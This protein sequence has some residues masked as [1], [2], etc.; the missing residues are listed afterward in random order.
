M[1]AF[2]GIPLGQDH[3]AALESACAVI[4]DIDTRWRNARWVPAGN[5]HVTLKFLGDVPDE[6]VG[7]LARDLAD[8][9][10]DNAQGS[11]VLEAIEA[12]R[13]ARRARMLWA[14]FDDLGGHVRH[15]AR[16]V[17]EIAAVYGVEPEGRE[18]VAHATLVRAKK[19]GP[20]DPDALAAAG[21]E[22]RSALGKDRVMSVVQA[23]LYKS[24]LTRAGAV[25]ETIADLP[26]NGTR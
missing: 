26:V 6:R 12:V 19:P 10:L 22:C 7:D 13:D 21:A 11:L 23:R 8:A 24:T 4:R 1:R 17:E 16:V 9:A 3:V 15:L 14:R 2:V 20:I 25:Y 18:F 5:L